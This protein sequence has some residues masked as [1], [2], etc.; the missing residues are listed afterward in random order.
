MTGS[1]SGSLASKL[2]TVVPLF[3]LMLKAPLPLLRMTTGGSFTSRMLMVTA[4]VVS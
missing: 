2:P 1:P 4:Y 3:S